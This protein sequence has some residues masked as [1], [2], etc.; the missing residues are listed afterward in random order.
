M[1]KLL[2]VVAIAVL[3]LAGNWVYGNILSQK[4]ESRLIHFSKNINA[5][6]NVQFEHIHVNPLLSKLQFNG[7]LVTTVDGKE[8]ASGRRVVLDMPYHE[9]IRLLNSKKVEELKSL[10]L[11]ILDLTV[12]L[13][14]QAGKVSVNSLVIDFDGHLRKDDIVNLQTVFPET[15]QRI[16]F[17]AE[18]VNWQLGD[19]TEAWGVT[20]GQKE[21]FSQVDQLKFQCQFN[22]A[23]KQAEIIKL[24]LDA[25]FFN[26][27]AMAKVAYEGDGLANVKITQSDYAF[28]L[29]LKEKGI[30]WGDASN[31]GRY[32]VANLSLKTDAAISYKDSV[33]FVQSQNFD[34]ELDNLTLEYAGKKKAQLEAKTALLGLKMDK[35]TVKKL[36]LHSGLE[37]NVL[38]VKGSELESSILDMSLKAKV[39][40]V[41][42]SIKTSRIDAATL[43]L[44]HLAPGIQNG[45]ST[46]ELMTG[47]SLPRQGDAIVLEMSGALARPTIK[48]LRY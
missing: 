29:D 4:I 14:E 31:N 36:S 48:G 40:L 1:K 13:D 17:D 33:P 25:P 18:G 34:L 22:P 47:Q 8:L 43:T 19:W 3:V 38:E 41:Q 21:Q 44:S 45:L 32:K 28:Q 30:E 37:A 15:K 12:I 24:Q 35:L 2:I 20:P 27:D 5:Q 16:D 23:G 39:Y 11:R 6:M 9:A 10:K 26:C 7:L 42:S 46:F